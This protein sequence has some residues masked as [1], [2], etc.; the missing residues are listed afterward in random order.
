[1]QRLLSLLVLAALM[2]IATFA[3]DAT[4]TWKG[5]A[6][7]PNGS[8]ERTFVL[9]VDGAKL[10][11]KATSSM[12]G[13]STIMDG[14]ADGDNLSFWITVKFGDNEMK[15]NYKG[16]VSGDTLKFTAEVGEN[17]IEWNCKRVQ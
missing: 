16:K 9:K 12:M 13:E 5:T 6:E 3:A 11:G 8:M 4:G 1:M 14:K 10:T 15:V 7:G 17:K 2:A